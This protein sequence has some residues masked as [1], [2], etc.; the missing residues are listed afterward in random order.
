MLL[1]YLYSIAIWYK[2]ENVVYQVPQ[3][4][5]LWDQTATKS[6]NQALLVIVKRQW[7]YHRLKSHFRVQLF[8]SC[9]GL[10]V[11]KKA[12]GGF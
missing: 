10:I 9:T 1:V 2:L 12:F 5:K 11:F 3:G 6:L 8:L 4:R 7:E